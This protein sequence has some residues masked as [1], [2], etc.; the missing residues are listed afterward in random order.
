M[1]KQKY[2]TE[3]QK[4]VK[5]FLVVLLGLVLIL[6]GIYFFTRAFVTKD[7]SKTNEDTTYQEGKINYSVAIVGTMLSRS[8]KEYYVFAFKESDSKKADYQK[9]MLNYRNQAKSLPIYTV[10]LDNELNKSY[11]AGEEETPSKSFEG[12]ENLKFGRITVLKIK[13]GKVEK[14]I[15]KEKEI[16]KELNLD[17]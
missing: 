8:S 3:E 2:E 11:V 5:K 12:L 9:Y 16:K 6:I 7:L 17:N 14:F 1:Q 13:N 4:E 15:T 10:D